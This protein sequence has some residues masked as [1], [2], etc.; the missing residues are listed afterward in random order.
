[1]ESVMTFGLIVLL[2]LAAFCAITLI[3]QAPNFA[4]ALVDLVPSHADIR[5]G[6]DARYARECQD[7]WEIKMYN[8]KTDRYGHICMTSS[9]KW[10][11][12]IVESTGEEVTAFL[13]EKMKT[14]DQVIRYM[15]NAGYMQ[16]K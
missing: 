2:V 14:L 4:E 9:G 5:H 3:Q 15:R 13:K 7:K 12:W 8:P 10:G 16:I 6:E 1:M 11:V